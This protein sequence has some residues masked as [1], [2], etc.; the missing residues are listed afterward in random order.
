MMGM[1]LSKRASF[2]LCVL[3][4]HLW[5]RTALA[6]GADLSPS[7]LACHLYISN[8]MLTGDIKSADLFSERIA[9]TI[10]SGL[11]AVVEFFFSLEARNHGSV[12]RGVLSY[13]LNYN[14]WDDY[15]SVESSDS[16]RTYPTYEAMTQA[17]QNLRYIALIPVRNMEPDGEYFLRLGVAVNPLCGSDRKKIAGWV[18]ENVRG[19]SGES[20]REQVLNLNDLIQHFFAKRKDAN[21]SEWFQ[22]K[23]FKPAALLE[24]DRRGE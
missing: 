10:Q 20:W 23:F 4:I 16:V 21:R 19:E 6:G 11:P 7:I 1:V 2:M 12:Q 13:E 8:E 15:Y 22:T 14:V 18:D 17:V 9:G 5:G 24:H 3:F